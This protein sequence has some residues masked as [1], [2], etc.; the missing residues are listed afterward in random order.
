MRD[1][2]A[3]QRDPCVM[4]SGG[5][6]K[7][8]TLICAEAVLLAGCYRNPEAPEAQAPWLAVARRGPS[9]YSRITARG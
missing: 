3:G 1:A 2:Q 5:A 4:F 6:I 9:Y 8:W 7:S